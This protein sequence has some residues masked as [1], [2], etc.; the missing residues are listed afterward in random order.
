MI[1]ELFF[2]FLVF[3]FG[4]LSAAVGK[5]RIS[6]GLTMSLFCLL[7]EI[8]LIPGDTEITESESDVSYEAP[9]VL[10]RL[11]LAFS[12]MFSCCGIVVCRRSNGWLGMK[13]WGKIFLFI[14]KIPVFL[15]Q[16]CS[17]VVQQV[18]RSLSW[19]AWPFIALWFLRRSSSF[20]DTATFSWRI[21]YMSMSQLDLLQ[22]SS[23][24][25]VDAYIT[26]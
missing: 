8:G 25:I 26:L 21:L 14:G 2:P 11:V 6:T 17:D 4:S 23:G 24:S 22:S 16:A 10:S 12:W 18:I 5:G 7:L 3:L 9:A 19:V 15:K 20:I 13:T 1:I